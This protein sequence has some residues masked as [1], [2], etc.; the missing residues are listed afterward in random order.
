M[1]LG[2][3][4]RLLWAVVR[5]DDEKF[6]GWG[7]CLGGLPAGWGGTGHTTTL[8]LRELKAWTISMAAD[9]SAAT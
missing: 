1:E 6:L 5:S 3:V 2:G 8:G 4:P 7:A 9:D